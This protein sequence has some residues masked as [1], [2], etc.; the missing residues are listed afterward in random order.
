[1]AND[2]LFVLQ[3]VVAIE[4]QWFAVNRKGP[5]VR[6]ERKHRITDCLF[7][8]V[9]EDDAFRIANEWLAG[10]SDANHDGEGDLTRIFAVGIHELEEVGR[11]SKVAHDAQEMYGIALPGFYLGDIDA[12]GV[13]LVRSKDQLRVFR[14]RKI[15]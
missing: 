6:T 8:A 5:P 15:S 1:M 12:S 10:Y 3:V 2:R 9:D 13:P 4:E 7:G 14:R 11:V